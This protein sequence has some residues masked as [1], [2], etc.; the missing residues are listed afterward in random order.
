MTAIFL[1]EGDV[2]SVADMPLALEAAERTFAELASGNAVNIPR[3]R[4]AAP[5]IMLHSMS[6]ASPG[7]MVLGTKTYVTTKEGAYFQVTL[8]DALSGRPLCIIEADYLG[9]LRTGA[10]S[11]LACR[12][13]SNPESQVVGCLGSGQQARTQLQAICLSRPIDRIEVYSRNS[14]RCLLFADEISQLCD[15]QTVA[16]H[17]PDEAASEKDI[18]VCATSSKTP[19]FQG[20]VLT[21]G[22]HLCVVG[23]NYR[24]KSEV[25]L[26]TIRR[27]DWIVCDDLAGSRNEAGDFL[28]AI[29]AGCLEWSRVQE[30]GKVLAG[31]QTGRAHEDD[32]TLFKS[33]GLAIQD[34]ILGMA[35]YERARDEGLGQKLP[36]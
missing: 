1:S 22:T 8:W 7:A 23:S 36:F 14:E 34:I 16:V 25:D 26:E 2:R 18:V 31:E 21:P 11:G 30:L 19:V 5:G 32:I 20:A 15:V 28:S 12:L 9:Q 4:A 24:T 35:I 6:A 29:E 17:S 33:V 3:S 27:S 10:A 13:M